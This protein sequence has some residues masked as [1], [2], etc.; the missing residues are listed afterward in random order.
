MARGLHV[1]TSPYILFQISHSDW[2]DELPK[3]SRRGSIRVLVV[4]GSPGSPLGHCLVSSQAGFEGGT[5]Q[6]L[7]RTCR[8]GLSGWFSYSCLS[9]IFNWFLV[10]NRTYYWIAFKLISLGTS[11]CFLVLPVSLKPYTWGYCHSFIIIDVND[12]NKP[13]SGMV[14]LIENLSFV[15]VVSSVIAELSNQTLSCESDIQ[16]LG[17]RV[18]HTT[19]NR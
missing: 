18:L 15:Q 8:E 5:H 10:P 4:P 2:A 11:L 7:V 17:G 19:P 12:F 16:H 9:V 6:P 3:S 13:Q 1:I 14:K